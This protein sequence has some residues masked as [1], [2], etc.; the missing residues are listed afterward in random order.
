MGVKLDVAPVYQRGRPRQCPPQAAAVFN[1]GRVD[2]L[3]FT[4]SATVHNFVKLV[5]KERLQAL[6]AKAT[7]AAIG[8]IT[9]TTLKEYGLTPQIEPVDYTIPALAAAIVDYFERNVS[10]K[11]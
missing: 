8:P 10:G 9:T 2:I 11:Q 1:A 7:V 5:G 3:T 6:A 4:S